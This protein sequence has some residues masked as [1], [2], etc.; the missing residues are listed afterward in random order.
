MT[1]TDRLKTLAMVAAFGAAALTASA[2]ETKNDSVKIAQK[3]VETTDSIDA[4]TKMLDN[5]TVSADAPMQVK[6]MLVVR[7]SAADVK[8]SSTAISLFQKLPLPGLEANPIT[9]ALSVDG[10]SP[11][12]LINGVPSTLNDL[13]ALQP[14]EI[15]KIEYSRITPIRYASNGNVGFLSITLKQRTDGG[16][17][18]LWGRSA[19]N[20]VFVNADLRASYHQ[21]ASQFTVSYSPSWRN[22]LHAYD[23]KVSSYIGH[24][25]R[26]DLTSTDR[27]PFNYHYH[28]MAFKYDYAPNIKTLFTATFRANPTYY[29]NRAIGH[30]FDSVTGEYDIRIHTKDTDFSPSLDLFFR[31]DFNDNN[32]LEAQIVG[33]IHRDHYRRENEYFYPDG[34]EQIYAT[35]AESRRNSLITEVSYIHAFHDGTQLS[36]GFQNTL[37]DSHNKYLYTGYRAKLTE[38]NNYIYIRAARNFGPLYLSLGTG[39][40]MYWM[41]NAAYK[42]HYIQN[43][44]TLQANWRISKKWNLSGAFTFVPSIPSLSSLTDYPQQVSPYLISNGAADLKGSRSVYFQIMPSYQYGKVMVAARFAYN[45]V[46]HPVIDDIRYIGNHLFLSQSIN[47]RHS[48]NMWGDLSFR[49]SGVA[50]FG[51]NINLGLTH[52]ETAATDWTDRLTSFNGS[53]TL[54]WNH[55][56]VTLSYWRKI[57]GKYMSGHYVGKDENGDALQIEY[58]PDKHWT[59]GASWM[60]M[61]D[62]KGTR[63]P[64][65]NYS[66]VNPTVSD[67]YIKDNGNMIVLSVTYNTNFGAIFRTARRNLNNSDN[68]SSLLKL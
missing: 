30:T 3:V 14:K 24:D 17:V 50:G 38:N 34:L 23:S 31:H 39:L 15:D 27:N 46:T 13:N 32:S 22:Y 20:T 2:Q 59:I 49:L 54:W 36:G 68:E 43:L 42:H 58:T 6:D 66:S 18:Y 52:Y 37:S 16:D 61:F 10:G 63:Y 41:N 29:G 11:Y 64:S 51:A 55:G 9:R 40:K 65:W 5:V 56:P 25:F 44:S 33:T 45:N 8:A 28:T 48:R 67:R 1:R 12:I 26:V 47:A 62:T 60:Y 4:T 7:P 35:N 57:P 21:Q 53:F 19:V